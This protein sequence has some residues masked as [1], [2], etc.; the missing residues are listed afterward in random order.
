MEGI[1]VRAAAL[2]GSFLG[3][4]DAACQADGAAAQAEHADLFDEDV[5]RDYFEDVWNSLE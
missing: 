3:V 4:S 2:A 5:L 1:V